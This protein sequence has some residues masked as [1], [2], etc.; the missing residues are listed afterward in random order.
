V[1]EDTGIGDPKFANKEKG[2]LFF[3]EVTQKISNAMVKLC[4]MDVNNSY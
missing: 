4:E 3:K 2:K 1:T